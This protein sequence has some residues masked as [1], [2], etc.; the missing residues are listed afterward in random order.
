VEKYPSR[1]LAL[2]EKAAEKRKAE[3]RG[4]VTQKLFYSMLEGI[5]KQEEEA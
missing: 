5:L 3:E 4:R 2:S 1:E